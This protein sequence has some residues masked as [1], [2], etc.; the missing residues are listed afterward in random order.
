MAAEALMGSDKWFSVN[1]CGAAPAL[2]TTVFPS[3]SVT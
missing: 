2:M 3:K 1:S